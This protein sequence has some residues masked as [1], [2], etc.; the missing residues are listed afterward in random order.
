MISNTLALDFWNWHRCSC[1]V[2]PRCRVPWRS[3]DTPNWFSHFEVSPTSPLRP[4]TPRVNCRQITPP[5][6]HPHLL[7][8]LLYF[9]QGRLM[10][11]PSMLFRPNIRP[12]GLDLPVVHAENPLL[13]LL[14]ASTSQTFLLC[15]GYLPHLPVYLQQRTAGSI[16]VYII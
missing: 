1:V 14:A 8:F 13:G 5:K 11:S 16:H 6:I 7:K 2:I 10:P 4:E 12:H 3:V 15:R 9:C